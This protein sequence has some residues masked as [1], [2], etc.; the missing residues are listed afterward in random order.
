MTRIADLAGVGKETAE[1]FAEL[2]IR[3]AEDLLNDFPFRYED[4]RF[5]TPAEKLGLKGAGADA[6][7]ENA[8]GTIVWVRERRARHLAIVEAELQDDTGTFVAKWFGRSYLLGAFKKG[9]RLFVRG[10]AQRT[11]AGATINVSAHKILA[12]GERYHGEVVPVYPA[13]KA[14]TSRKI[15]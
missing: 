11:L 9:M 8:V 15:R 10:R 6:P 1:R 4:L 3:T 13:G 12:N 5:P 7:E 2:G 14:L